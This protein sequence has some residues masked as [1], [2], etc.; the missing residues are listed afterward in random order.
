LHSSPEDKNP[1]KEPKPELRQ[2]DEMISDVQGNLV[3][4]DTGIVLVR[5][6]KRDSLVADGGGNLVDKDAGVVM[7]EQTGVLVADKE[8][9]ADFESKGETLIKKIKSATVNSPKP[10]QNVPNDLP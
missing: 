7:F 10:E 5:A 8:Q 1:L 2:I 4:K 3:D 9:Q 6:A